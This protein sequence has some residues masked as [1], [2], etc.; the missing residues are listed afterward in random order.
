MNT[1]HIII[2]LIGSFTLTKRISELVI[3][4]KKKD[5]EKVKVEVL[6]LLLSLFVIGILLYIEK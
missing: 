3:S 1:F 5:T 4:I 6:F 2:L